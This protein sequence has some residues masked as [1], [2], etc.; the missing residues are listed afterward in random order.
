MSTLTSRLFLPLTLAAALG[1][2]GCD[3]QVGDNGVSLDLAQGKATDEWVRTYSLPASGRLEIVNANGAIDAEP[4]S[5]QQVEVRIERVARAG[6][7]EDARKLLQGLQMDEQVS[8]DRVRIE[9]RLPEASGFRRRSGITLRYHVRVPAGLAASFETANGGIR[10]SD[11]NA[12]IEATTTNGGITAERM[13]GAVKATA[14][15][16]GIRV[17]MA[18]VTGD[19]E[20][21]ITNGG[22][23]LELPIDTR[24]TLDASCVNGGVRVDD[25][26]KMQASEVSRRRVAGTLNGGGPKIVAS[27]VN[28]GINISARGRQSD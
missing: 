20:V 17:E 23:R 6:S 18:S 5:G 24:A 15:N 4:A 8:K 14:V 9:A 26:L 12:R 1:A 2:G 3:I 22:I 27:T 10:L 13:S 7:D 19:V 11:L 16:G 21:S 25:D 28:G